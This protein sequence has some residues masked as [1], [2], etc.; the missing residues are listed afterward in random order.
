MK[1]SLKLLISVLLVLLFTHI[2]AGSDADDLINKGH[3]YESTG[4]YE[5]ALKLYDQAI[6]LN[7]NE[8]YLYLPKYDLLWKTGRF[9]EANEVW[10]LI[11]DLLPNSTEPI[12]YYSFVAGGSMTCADYHSRGKDYLVYKKNY[13]EALFYFH[14]VHEMC[15]NDTDIGNVYADEGYALYKLGRLEE[16][17]NAYDMALQITQ[18]KLASDPKRREYITNNEIARFNRQII[19]N[20]AQVTPSPTEEIERPSPADGQTISQQTTSEQQT[21]SATGMPLPWV[22]SFS[23]IIL[24]IIILQIRKLR[25]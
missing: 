6:L 10:D 25:I 24:A 21:P 7:P 4:K 23:G 1:I 8:S 11:M 12:Y 20:K 15:P 14:R 18:Q 22:L 2:A 5:D 16:S 13:E 17:L 9:E 3:V 19:A